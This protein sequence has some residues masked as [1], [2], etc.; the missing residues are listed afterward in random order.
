MGVDELDLC[1]FCVDFVEKGP[2]ADDS[3]AIA[4]HPTYGALITSSRNCALCACLY[5]LLSEPFP[6][7]EPREGWALQVVAQHS[8][9][10]NLDVSWGE[11]ELRARSLVTPTITEAKFTLAT[12]P[13]KGKKYTRMRYTRLRYPGKSPP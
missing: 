13:S 5:S 2:E 1:L 4:H 10:S 11:Y 3:T 7:G 8:G 6:E 12:R 9:Q